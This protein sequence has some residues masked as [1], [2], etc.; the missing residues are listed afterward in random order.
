MQPQVKVTEARS[1]GSLRS[2]I[3]AE[4]HLL[5]EV[6]PDLGREGPYEVGRGGDGEDTALGEVRRQEL[7]GRPEASADTAMPG[8]R[9]NPGRR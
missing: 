4:T 6:I 8:A 2:K 7:S 3:V 1:E 9:R 5:D